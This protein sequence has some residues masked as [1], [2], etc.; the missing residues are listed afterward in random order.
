MKIALVPTFVVRGT[1]FFLLLLAGCSSPEPVEVEGFNLL[2]FLV[3]KE[4]G[5]FRGSNIGESMKEVEKR[6]AQTPAKLNEKELKYVIKIPEKDSAYMEVFYQFDQYGLFEIQ[7]D[8][9]LF[10]QELTGQLFAEFR[11]HFDKLYGKSTMDSGYTS[12]KTLSKR[13]YEINI[14]LIDE[15]EDY[16]YSLLSITFHEELVYN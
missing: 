8:V 4:A 6:E 7:A 5:H 3:G 1:L 10:D 16:G 14:S 9:Y 12:W 13:K 15:S 2:K 11:T